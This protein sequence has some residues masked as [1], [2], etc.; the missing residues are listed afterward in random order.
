MKP[1][2]EW[3]PK[4]KEELYNEMTEECN[5]KLLC[6]C[7]AKNFP[8]GYLKGACCGDGDCDCCDTDSGV[9]QLPTV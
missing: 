3:V 6:I 2:F 9:L 8:F 5:G 7:E 4:D 1:S